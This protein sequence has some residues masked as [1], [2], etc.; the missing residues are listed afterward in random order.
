MYLQIPSSRIHVEFE[1]SISITML[2]NFTY[3]YPSQWEMLYAA[4]N[5][6]TSKGVIQIYPLKYPTVLDSPP[7]NIWVYGDKQVA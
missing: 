4:N 2:V 5:F 7:Q 6:P 3:L 1:N